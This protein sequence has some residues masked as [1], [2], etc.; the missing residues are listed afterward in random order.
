MHKP[1]LEGLEEY[2]AGRTVAPRAQALAAHL[3]TCV[4]CRELVGGMRAQSAM[5]GVLKAEGEVEPLP[6]FYARVMERI[7]AQ[8]AGSLWSFILEPFVVRR[9]MYASLAL[10]LVFGVAAATVNNGVDLHQVLPME[11]AAEITLPD[12]DSYIGRAER[13]V[14]LVNLASF[15]D[16]LPGGSAVTALPAMED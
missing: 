2:L 7:E 9:F 10:M 12:A 8:A 6:G 5:L 16:G 15:G 3:E 13:D 11:M 4:E 1:E 14:V